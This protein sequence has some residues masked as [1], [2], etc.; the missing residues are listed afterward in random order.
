M[1]HRRAIVSDRFG[2]VNAWHSCKYSAVFY[3]SAWS[4]AEIAAARMLLFFRKSATMGF[5]TIWGSGNLG[6]VYAASS[7][8]SQF[9]DSWLSEQHQ[10]NR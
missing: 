7:R 3:L 1:L 4:A 2:G 6:L 10:E 5:L 8:L 9:L